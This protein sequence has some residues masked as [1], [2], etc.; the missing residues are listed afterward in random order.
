MWAFFQ[1][2]IRSVLAN[3]V[4][5]GILSVGNQIQSKLF[6]IFSFKNNVIAKK[7]LLLED[8]AN[9]NWDLP[10]KFNQ[11]QYVYVTEKWNSFWQFRQQNGAIN[12]D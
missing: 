11:T 2:K 1:K 6:S 7:N 5:N 12:F 3:E 8:Q 9:F 10:K 4:K